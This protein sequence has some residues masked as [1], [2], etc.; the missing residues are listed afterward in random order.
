VALAVPEA[1][2]WLLARATRLATKDPLA[3]ARS[4]EAVR[5]VDDTTALPPELGP[6][7]DTHTV[8]ALVA[9][10][11]AQWLEGALAGLRL[12]RAGGLFPLGADA[13]RQGEIELQLERLLAARYDEWAARLFLARCLIRGAPPDHEQRLKRAEAEL[14][15]VLAAPLGTAARPI[16]LET[17]GLVL[18]HQRRLPEAQA[19]FE[20]ALAAWHPAPDELLLDLSYW[21][22]ESDPVPSLAWAERAVAARDARARGEAE[23]GRP[24]GLP[25]EPIDHARGW[26]AARV[27]A[28]LVLV[29]RALVVD[30]RARALEV[31]RDCAGLESPGPLAARLI[32][33]AVAAAAGKDTD[34]R[35]EVEPLRASTGQDREE[36]S[37]LAPWLVSYVKRTLRRRDLSRLLATDLGVE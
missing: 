19:A 18:A 5:L 21:S 28:R 10:D 25:L 6:A 9:G 2:D 11:E 35:T 16:A 13:K 23:P 22:R 20:G 8:G 34:A 27:E 17:L 29:E 26:Q 14:G 33:A 7:L 15:K 12:G 32:R 24:R 3:A 30:R 36:L 1:L 4:A 31:A 37:W